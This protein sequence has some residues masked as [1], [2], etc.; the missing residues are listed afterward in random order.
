MGSEEGRGKGICLFIE[1][2]TVSLG[3]FACISLTELCHMTIPA[4]K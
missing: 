3:T 2:G 4:A 1:E